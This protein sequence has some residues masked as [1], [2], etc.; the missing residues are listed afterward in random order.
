MSEHYEEDR[1]PTSSNEKESS[2]ENN[3]SNKNESSTEIKPT[4]M[5]QKWVKQ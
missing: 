3:S 1:S 2:T 4:I 5:E